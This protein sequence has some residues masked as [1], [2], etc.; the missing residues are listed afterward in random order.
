MEDRLAGTSGGGGFAGMSKW[1]RSAA[2]F[3]SQMV[4]L[5][6]DVAAFTAFPPSAA[7]SGSTVS[8]NSG[9]SGEP[10]SSNCCRMSG[11]EATV[12]EACPIGLR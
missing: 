9:G 5:S 3:D 12:L 8:T 2:A 4:H 6:Y 1:R 10:S 7:D 11:L